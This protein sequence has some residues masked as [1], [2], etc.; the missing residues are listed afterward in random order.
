MHPL[1]R[2]GTWARIA[3]TLALAGSLSLMSSATHAMEGAA[4][5]TSAAVSVPP[6]APMEDVRYA[7]E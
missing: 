4:S 2:R 7:D 5:A 1:R 6:G 3:A